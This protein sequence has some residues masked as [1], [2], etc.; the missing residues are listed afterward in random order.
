MTLDGR[1]IKEEDGEENGILEDCAVL[2]VLVLL[3]SPLS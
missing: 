3:L 1:K 2:S